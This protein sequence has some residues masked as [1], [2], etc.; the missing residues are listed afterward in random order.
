MGR[1][2]EALAQCVLSL[3]AKF[4]DV[5][6]DGFCNSC[7]VRPP[8]LSLPRCRCYGYQYRTVCSEKIRTTRIEKLRE[9]FHKK[10]GF[11]FTD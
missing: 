4:C 9:K 10:Y 8:N 2:K 5:G 3:Q 6:I 1:I 7:H 11:D